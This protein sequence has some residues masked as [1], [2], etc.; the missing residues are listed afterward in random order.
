MRGGL[1][2]GTLFVLPG[3]F[4]MLL[5]SV[6]FVT[7]GD[8]PLVAGALFGIQCAVLVIVADALLRVARRALA[9]P[10]ALGVAIAAFAALFFGGVPFPVV[11]L[12]AALVGMFASDAFGGATARS[13]DTGG[14]T[15]DGGLIDAMFDA[16]PA[17]ARARARGARRAGGWALLLWLAPVAALAVVEGLWFDIA[18][19]FS[20]LAVV[21]FGGAYAVL[22]YMAQEAVEGYRWLDADAMLVGLGLAE[23][24]PGPLILVT[25]FVG[26]MAG[27]GSSTGAAALG[28]GALA[29]AL[30]LWVT[31]APCFAFVFLGAPLIEGLRRNR[32]L[33]GAL[34]AIT[35][36]VVG[37]IANLALW[38]GLHVLFG[39]QRSVALGPLAFDWPVLASVS[40]LAVAITAIA[41]VALLRLRAGVVTTLVVCA[42]AGA[43]L[44]A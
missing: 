40:W 6:L 23:T 24:T 9:G 31:F 3:A 25:Q 29:S 19:F 39:E 44:G 30:T 5:L 7:M 2:A 20:K 34:A 22:A 42:A 28:A 27:W 15:P 10:F 1:I 14:G 18:W 11:V 4:V 8:A 37:V 13:T 26:F 12:G 35:A 17:F 41:A 32:R 21:T 43:L 36:A 38:F 33:A 16:D